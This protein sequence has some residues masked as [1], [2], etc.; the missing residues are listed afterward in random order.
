MALSD[1]FPVIVGRSAQVVR[2]NSIMPRLVNRDLAADLTVQGSTVNVPV[3]ATYTAQDVVPGPT[4]P[5]GNTPA[6]EVVPVQLNFWKDAYF[7]LNDREMTSLASNSDYVP[8]SMQAAAEAIASAV[9]LSILDLYKQTSNLANNS[10]AGPFNS[11]FSAGNGTLFAQRAALILSLNKAPLTDRHIV[12]DPFAYSDATGLPQLQQ[13]QSSGTTE[14]IREGIITR[15]LGFSWHQDQNVPTHIRGGVPVTA[16]AVNNAGG[17]PIGARIIA[18][19]GL[20]AM[21]VVGD[22]F[23][24]ASNNTPFAVVSVA[25]SLPNA[26]I[27]LGR[28][29]PFVVADNEVLTFYADH[30]PCL[31]FHRDAI[32]FAS[33]PAE[34]P[35]QLPGV[36]MM[37]YLDDQSGLALTVEIKREHH[38]TGFYISC[39]WGRSLIRSQ[40]VTRIGGAVPTFV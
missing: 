34:N 23:R 16:I 32:A 36:M 22:I 1:L 26:V 40:W 4:P 21:P 13:A 15:A 24:F 2:A 18:I 11:P 17:Y 20:S 14:T 35:L 29:L 8:T 10:A 30:V 3:P 33:R 7:H 5:P 31:A 28:P 9:D 25:G 19:D 12:L 6:D 37:T 39:M 38:R 27:T